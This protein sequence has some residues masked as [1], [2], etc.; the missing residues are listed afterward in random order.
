MKLS[1]DGKR[2][3]GIIVGIVG[4]TKNLWSSYRLKAFMGTNKLLLD[5]PIRAYTKNTTNI[6]GYNSFDY[7][8]FVIND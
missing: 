5:N 6:A 1:C 8:W 4:L 7:Y 2:G 3:C